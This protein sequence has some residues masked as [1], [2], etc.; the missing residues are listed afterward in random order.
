M[1]QRRDNGET[2]NRAARFSRSPE[3]GLLLLYPI[4]R[5]SGYDLRDPARPPGNREPLYENPD[6]P[7]SRDLVGLAISFP[8]SE[9]AQQ[10]EAYLEG[11]A[12]WRPVE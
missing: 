4:S 11:T 1:R 9:H 10:V 7:R 8:E 5:Y 2:E 3:E 12:G 6:D